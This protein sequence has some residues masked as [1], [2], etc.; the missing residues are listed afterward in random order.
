MENEII[1]V[2]STEVAAHNGPTAGEVVPLVLAGATFV[3]YAGYMAWT[4]YKDT[5]ARKKAD[6]IADEQ[7]ELLRMQKEILSKPDD[8]KK[9]E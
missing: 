1:T 8:D 5:K 4:F 9:D 3:I 2:G 7:L 6:K